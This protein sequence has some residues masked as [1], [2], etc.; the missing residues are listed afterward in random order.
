VAAAFTFTSLVQTLGDICVSP[1]QVRSV[2]VWLLLVGTNIT[3]L[4]SCIYCLFW[5]WN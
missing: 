5:H 2:L 4:C 3:L 1:L